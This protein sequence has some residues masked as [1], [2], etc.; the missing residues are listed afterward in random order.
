MSVWHLLFLMLLLWLL[1][2]LLLPA[3]SI[4]WWWWL[5]LS[6]LT[7]QLGCWTSHC[8][9]Q[10]KQTLCSCC[11]D[12]CV[13]ATASSPSYS[14]CASFKSSRT[15][16]T[17]RWLLV[18]LALTVRRARM[19]ARCRRAATVKI[20]ATSSLS[21]HFVFVAAVAAPSTTGTAVE[22]PVALE[23]PSVRSVAE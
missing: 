13:L 5:S 1:L 15:C 7:S 6:A 16:T 19:T 12:A 14:G 10:C 22:V 2:L 9:Q 8:Q 18:H 20:H 3:L 4:A 17:V 23:S 11:C 21:A